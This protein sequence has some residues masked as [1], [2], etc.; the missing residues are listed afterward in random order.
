MKT[1]PSNSRYPV[2][3]AITESDGRIELLAAEQSAVLV[4]LEALNGRIRTTVELT[5]GASVGRPKIPGH[6]SHCSLYLIDVVEGPT[7]IDMFDVDFHWSDDG[8]SLIG[9]S[10]QLHQIIGPSAVDDQ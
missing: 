2:I 9:S 7:I 6:S 10:N 4:S 3:L 5:I 1:E 8:C